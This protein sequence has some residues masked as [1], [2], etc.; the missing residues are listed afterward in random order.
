MHYK[1][2][3][4]TASPMAF[5]KALWVLFLLLCCFPALY[6]Q[7]TLN[8]SSNANK[9]DTKTYTIS[10]P[11]ITNTSWSVTNGATITTSSISSVTVRF[12]NTG[13]TVITASILGADWNA[14]SASKTVS[15]TFGAPSAP[16]N[17][18]ISSNNCGQATL[19]RTGSP[20]SGVTWY[21]QG[22]SS[23]GT[24]T[25]KGSGST[26]IANEGNG[27]YYIRARN[28]SGVWSVSS[29]VASVLIANL[30]GGTIIG[31]ST[32]CYGGNPG[33]IAN[34][35]SGT[36]GSGGYTYQ[37]QYSA[38]GSS[39]WTNI[40]GATSSSYNPPGGLTASRWYRRRIASC[41][42]QNA[43]SNTVK[44]T[45]QPN[46]VAG[47]IGG[48][49]SVCYN[50]DPSTLSSSS[51]ASGGN[52]SYA[53]QWQ[54]SANGSSGWTN[55]SGATSTTYNP[56][57]GLTASRWYRRRAISCSQTKY[58]GSVK[59]TVYTTP[60]PG[61][62]GGTQTICYNGDPGTLTSSSSAS[63]GNGSYAYQWQYSANGSSGWT[64][65]S[66]ATTTTYNPPS[67]LTASRWYR[68]RTISCG[69]TV[70]TG[71]IK[72]TVNPTLVV[73]GINGAHSICSGGDPNT[74]GSSTLPTGGNGSYTYQW[75]YSANGSSGWTNISGASATTYNPPSG[76]TVSRW[77]RRA[78]S[79]CGQTLYTGSVKVTVTS[80]STWYEDSDGDGF[81]DPAVST[82]SCT[83]PANYVANSDDECPNVYS[84]NPNGCEY[85]APS[86]SDG[87]YVSTRSYQVATTDPGATGALKRNSDVLEAATYYDGLGR[88]VQRGGIKASSDKK[89]IIAHMGYDEYGR[90]KKE[91]LPYYEPTGSVG[92]YRSGDME[93]ATKQYYKDNYAADYPGVT[94]VADINAYSEKAFEASPLN[95]VLKQAA[96]GKDW[97]MGGGHEIEFAYQTNAANEVRHFTVTFSG[98]DPEVPQLSN[99]GHYTAK[100]LYKNVTYDENHS[101]GTDHSMEEYTDKLGRVVLKRTYKSGAH[102]TYYV[103]DDFGNLTYVLPP[104]V[105]TD[106][107]SS[108][109][110]SELCYQYKYD[111]RNRL[112]EKKVPGKDWEYIIYNP[113]DQ[114]VMTQ[115]ANLRANNQWLFTKYDAFGRVAFTGLI[116]NS[117]G[118]SGMQNLANNTSLYDLYETRQSSSSTIAGTQIYYSNNTIPGTITEI[119]TVTYYD[120]YV[121]SDGLNV[122]ATVLGQPKA[123]NT[124]GLP[125][126]SKVRVLGTTNWITTITGYD[127]KARPIYVANK[128][129]YL[130]TVDAVLTLLD[131]PGKVLQTKADHTKAGQSTITTIDDFTYDH[132][133]RLIKQTQT[134]GSH[135]EVLVQNEYDELGQLVRKKVGNTESTPL[136]TVDYSYNVRGWLKQ[137][138]D[139]ANLGTDLFAFDI[140]YNTADHGGTALYNGNVSE[141]EWKTANDNVLRWY[142][143][144]YDVLNR[145][146]DATANSSNYNVS[147]ISYDK[148]GNILTLERQGHTNSGATTFSTMDDLTYTYDSGNQLMKVADAAAIDGFGFKDDAVNTAADTVN[149]Y[150]YDANGN[151]LTD[152]NKGIT[153][154]TY[155]H[156]NLPTQVTLASGNIQY[157]YDATG[158]KQKKVV[159]ETGQSSVTTEYAGNHVYENSTL[160]FFNH[161]E[162]YVEPDGSNWDY[163][164]QYMDHLGNIRLSYSDD[165]GNGSIA[166][167]EIRE[168]NNYY[169]FG[170]KH[171]GYN[172]VQNG[173]DH[174]FEFQGQEYTEDLGLNLQEFKYRMHDPSIG[175]FI[176][177]DPL[178]E[179]YAYNGTYNFA[180]NRVIEGLEIEGLET[181]AIHGTFVDE[182][183]MTSTTREQISKVFGTKKSYSPPWSGGNTHKARVEAASKIAE[184]V[185]KKQD[186]SE[187]SIALVG[188]SHGGN[189]AILAAN[190]LR[191]KLGGD[192]TINLLTINTPVRS[193][194][195][196]DA[197]TDVSHIN[198]FNNSDI[199]QVLG[200][201]DTGE[202]SMGIPDS[203]EKSIQ[204]AGREFETA[205]NVQYDDQFSLT[206]DSGCGLTGH[207][208]QA[209]RNTAEWLPKVEGIR[210]KL[211]EVGRKLRSLKI[212]EQTR[213]G[214][215]QSKRRLGRFYGTN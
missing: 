80:P 17:P 11:G 173:R 74:L 38:N 125:T 159:N 212:S 42:G 101:S 112:V 89:D 119:H 78:D 61:G 150:T 200:G 16:A 185:M 63:G 188:H 21:W 181:F 24:S 62:I 41:S 135:T 194:Y 111:H 40:G 87:N 37:W 116:V 35:N 210:N 215:E 50:G 136:Q 2:Q 177:I 108:T 91:W 43:Y 189:V 117:N 191:D 85:I 128:N 204:P 168:E 126:V 83:Q 51:S 157:I 193:E 127:N 123:S 167:S 201:Q 190:I 132:A 1:T 178:A 93:T 144:G 152:T 130:N 36:G 207:C 76:L 39:G 52:G 131:F 156:L 4:T 160:Q 195:Q 203:P 184:F 69:Q 114:P 143:Y 34:S 7:Y 27:G 176:Q 138:N 171:K 13:N 145:I 33:N 129:N 115:D 3:K 214:Q 208:G 12:N 82:T 59:V 179:D 26:F 213:E 84:T 46:L 95:R 71:N 106:N 163:V 161:P 53:Y 60:S 105:T 202:E 103:Y 104:K 23:S 47:S 124:Q 44:I 28:S 192:V 9:N 20:P 120:S 197:D 30:G 6:G 65:I 146:T 199:V 5:G 56:P 109:E 79:S 211:K 169:P 57:S 148:M 206:D 113:L 110:L 54:Y 67:G 174:K 196:L 32:I 164:Y 94:N 18:T 158:V 139:P 73:G 187:S 122:P 133:A 70:Y 155:N 121:D 137:I 100:T 102:D 96:P 147:G 75:Q 10:G 58:T 142:R 64:N 55:I 198:V 86:M 154:I 162:G 98:G 49:Q 134:I 90:Q 149:D 209:D 151:M 186:P 29:G 140:N 77:Y 153:S 165:N 175:R 25:S 31:A 205:I 22:K 141:T 183:F 14:Y 48:V 170:L 180:E 66:G 92:S 172:V 45:V 88:P 72:V 166:T 15:V 97:K 107:V 81:G 182:T 99:N 118:R 8:G 19:Q 68:R